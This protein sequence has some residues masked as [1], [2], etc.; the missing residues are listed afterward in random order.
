V[1]LLENDIP[2]RDQFTILPAQIVSA[3]YTGS[4][5]ATIVV[6]KAELPQSYRHQAFSED[7]LKNFFSI[8]PFQLDEH[9]LFYLSEKEITL[10]TAGWS[11]EQ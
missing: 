5:V 7:N 8:F 3:K 4:T 6:T 10:K 2:G 11:S 9:K 1:A